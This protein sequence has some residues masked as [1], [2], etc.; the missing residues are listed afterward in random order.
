MQKQ[1]QSRY[2]KQTTHRC[3]PL[4]QQLIQKQEKYP[5]ATTPQASDRFV[6]DK[7]L[8]QVLGNALKQN[9][10]SSL[11]LLIRTDFGCRQ[12]QISMLFGP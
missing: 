4:G 3:S 11:Y 2:H 12:D 5:P 6:K 8:G 7:M 9:I 10:L 1:N